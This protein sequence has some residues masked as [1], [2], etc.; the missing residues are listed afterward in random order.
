MLSDT[1]LLNI[2]RDS[3]SNR[4]GGPKLTEAVDRKLIT[5][6]EGFCIVKTALIIGMSERA[7]IL[8]LGKHYSVHTYRNKYGATKQYSWGHPPYL[9]VYVENGKVTSWSSY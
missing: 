2:I 1:E 6:D 7:M 8:T 3:P 9:F 4:K 5:M